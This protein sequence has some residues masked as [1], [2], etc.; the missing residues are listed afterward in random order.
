MCARVKFMYSWAHKGHP[1]CFWLSGFFFPHGFLT[2]TLQTYA[3]KRSKPIDLL[4]FNF[5]LTAH[6]EVDD[7][8]DAPEDGVYIYGLFIQGA[9]W[10]HKDQILVEPSPGEMF[11]QM[12]IIHFIPEEQAQKI[13]SPNA[14][15]KKTDVTFN[16][17]E[18][19]E[20]PMDNFYTCPVYKTSERAGVLSTTG[21]STNFILAVR[22]PCV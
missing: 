14:S 22:L 1:A 18:S 11:C 7:I 2:G 19:S 16:R 10:S 3:R 6:S 12:P 21:Q 15:P 8:Y 17:S 20:D 13:S 5:K 4:A 9:K